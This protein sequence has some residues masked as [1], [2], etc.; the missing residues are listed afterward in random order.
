MKTFAILA[1]AC[2]SLMF[3]LTRPAHADEVAQR[4]VASLT[5]WA[6][7]RG[8]E[9]AQ[10]AVSYQGEV[11]AEEA[12]GGPV[13]PVDIASLSKAITAACVQ[14]L[15]KRDLLD[16]D[17]RVRLYLPD[18]AR[19]LSKV[20]LTDLVTHTAG[21]APDGTQGRMRNWRGPGDPVHGNILLEVESRALQ[22]PTYFYNNE[23][24]A[25]LAALIEGA[26]GRPYAEVCTEFVLTPIGATT[27]RPSANYG[28]FAA[29]GGWEMTMGDYTRLMWARFGGTDPETLPHVSIG[30]G[31]HYGLG[32]VWRHWN[33]GQNHWHFGALCFE[34]TPGMFSF[35]VLFKNGWSAAIR[36]DQCPQDDWFLS[37]DQAI[38]TAVFR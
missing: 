17:D 14:E 11:R 38:Y 23:N 22:S 31:V 18:V 1:M 29:W 34:D 6:N 21:I 4:V 24:Y 2:A 9:T 26:S 5:D 32:M 13:V 16:W 15:V 10:I 19:P 30:N 33:G 8:I 35:G 36:V 3:G 28:Q 37:V 27:A 12:I 25:I 20:R 7:A